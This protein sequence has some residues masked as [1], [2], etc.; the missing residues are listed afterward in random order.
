MKLKMYYFNPNTYSAEYFTVAPDKET[1]FRK[2]EEIF[3]ITNK[4]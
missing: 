2:C 1:C 3:K 4:R